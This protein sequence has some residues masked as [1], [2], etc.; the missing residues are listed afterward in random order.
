MP[1]FFQVSSCDRNKAS[2]LI[3]Y[4]QY[5]RGTFQQRIRLWM[6]KVYLCAC[7]SVFPTVSTLLQN[8]LRP[9]P[10]PTEPEGAWGQLCALSVPGQSGPSC[11]C[12]ASGDVGGRVAEPFIIHVS[13]PH[14][15]LCYPRELRTHLSLPA[16]HLDSNWDLK[17]PEI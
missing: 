1:A 4:V 15:Y 12:R 14:N 16:S 13:L 10:S 11:K 8:Q 5:S 6:K 3:V 2:E 17:T 7:L 9:S